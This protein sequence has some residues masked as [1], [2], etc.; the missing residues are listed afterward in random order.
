[1]L[2]EKGWCISDKTIRQGYAHVCTL[3]GLRGRWETLSHSPLTI[4]DTG[5]NSHGIRY[6]ADH[7]HHLLHD[8]SDATQSLPLRGESVV[9]CRSR[10]GLYIV[11]GMV[12]DKDVDIVLSLL[13]KQ[14]TYFFTQAQTHRAIPAHTLQQLAVK[15]DLQ[16]TA[17]PTTIEALQAA[18]A[19]A[20]SNDI[21]FIGGSN[22][23]VGE[24]LQLF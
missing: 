23:I 5:H 7:L 20:N 14:A 8:G 16:G 18:Q 6:V 2:S 22:Y 4:C 15:H 24:A 3:T 12:N 1:M 10:R 21:I 13:P 19:Q 11:F 9:A 17:Y